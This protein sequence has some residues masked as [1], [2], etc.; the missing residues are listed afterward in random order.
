MLKICP[1]PHSLVGGTQGL[2]LVQALRG[3]S[4]VEET[5]GPVPDLRV[6]VS[7]QMSMAIRQTHLPGPGLGQAWSPLSGVTV[8]WGRHGSGRLEVRVESLVLGM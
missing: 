8:C 5:Q 2:G 3:H 4:L 6:K 7:L 1:K